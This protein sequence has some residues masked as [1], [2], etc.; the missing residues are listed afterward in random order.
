[1]INNW[2]IIKDKKTYR[3]AC[4]RY[5]EVKLAVKG[6]DE[7]KEKMLLALLINQYEEKHSQLPEADPI[8]LIKI[9]ME[10]SAIRQ[11]TWHVNMVI[12]ER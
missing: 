2:Y 9:R 1:M 12:K 10:D 3:L 7:H 6:S 11:M 8:E 5:E 4:K